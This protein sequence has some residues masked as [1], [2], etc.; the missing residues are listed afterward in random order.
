MLHK[1]TWPRK[2]E[3]MSRLIL[4]CGPTG[5]GKTT[6]SNALSSE[7]KAV[8]FSIDPWMNTLYSKD[9]TSLD[10][11]WMIERVNRCYDQIWEV[12]SQ[13]LE[14]GG[15]VVLDLG[16]TEKKHRSLFADWALSKDIVAEVHYLNASREIR[17]QRVQ[18]RNLEKETDVY[19]FEVT[20]FM[21][22]FME[23]RFEIP[24]QDEL[25]HGIIID[26]D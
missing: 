12:T 18:K 10:Y 16:F 19:V 3:N 13:I 6:Y 21:F 26:T 2:T 14:H 9:M 11:E 8:R 22:E 25:K 17:E 24:D 4:V 5:V 7:I 23:P 1:S 20:E 15:N